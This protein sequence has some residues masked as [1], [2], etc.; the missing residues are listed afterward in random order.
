MGSSSLSLAAY[1]LA[2]CLGIGPLV[3]FLYAKPFVLSEQSSLASER[4]SML[5]GSPFISAFV[6]LG[7]FGHFFAIGYLTVCSS[8][9]ATSGSTFTAVITVRLVVHLAGPPL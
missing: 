2:W 9:T 1:S 4:G 3:A 8:F 7:Y 6:S 5:R